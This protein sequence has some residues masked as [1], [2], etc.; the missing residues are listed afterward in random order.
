MDR[1][2]GRTHFQALLEVRFGARYNELNEGLYRFVDR[3]LSAISLLAGAAAFLN[4]LVE[5]DGLTEW[6]GLII[7]LSAIVQVL[8]APAARMIEHREL[9]RRFT[10]LAGRASRLEL[11]ELDAEI[12]RL[13]AGAPGGFDALNPLAQANVL[14]NAGYP[15]PKVGWWGS[16]VGFFC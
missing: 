9:A 7:A 11:P 4:L 3:L 8:M 13:R 6:A 12:T 1:N 2:Y 14:E 5:L 10:Q 15:R 16:F